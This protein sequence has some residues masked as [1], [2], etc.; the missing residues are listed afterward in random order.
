MEYLVFC[1]GI[2]PITTRS[3]A[4]SGEINT[5][6]QCGGVSVSPGD[7]ILADDNG[8]L[9]IPPDRVQDVVERCEPRAQREPETRARLRAGEKL[10]EISG[11]G[12]RLAEALERQQ[13]S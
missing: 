11:N 13:Q 5:I 8:V 12:Q 4:V 2:S 3:L 7:I 6:V 9:V 1:R 10:T